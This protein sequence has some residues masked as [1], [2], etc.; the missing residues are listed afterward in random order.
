M[1]G[2][3][4]WV[5]ELPERQLR[6]ADHP[7]ATSCVSRVVKFQREK[8][9]GRLRLV[10]DAEAIDHLV[11]SFTHLLRFR[12]DRGDLSPAEVVGRDPDLDLI[13][14]FGIV[15][16]GHLQLTRRVAPLETGVL[17][18][19][20][21]S[22]GRGRTEGTRA[23]QTDQGRGDDRHHHQPAHSLDG[24]F[25]SLEGEISI[26]LEVSDR[27]G[28]CHI[29]ASSWRATGDALHVAIAGVAPTTACPTT[30]ENSLVARSSDLQLERGADRT[31]WLAFEA[32][33]G[34]GVLLAQGAQRSVIG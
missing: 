18:P 32:G 19:E 23:K 6:A 14:T 13:L 27:L 30:L 26:E 31:D 11:I 28:C 21:S 3:L 4:L 25:S 12:D 8:N 10:V 17:E 24:P 33:N 29:A 9:C 5:D 20:R 22:F 15:R 7:H 34:A 1:S 16:D 2:G